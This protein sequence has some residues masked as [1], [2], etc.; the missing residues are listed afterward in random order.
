MGDK[1]RT[2][3][4]GSILRRRPRAVLEAQLR[5][6]YLPEINLHQD[7][8]YPPGGSYCAKWASARQSYAFA[9]SS[10]RAKEGGLQLQCSFDKQ[11]CRR[12]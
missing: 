4:T 3:T 7:F 5:G 1:L 11:P 6:P 12:D 2:P 9:K 8:R 10:S